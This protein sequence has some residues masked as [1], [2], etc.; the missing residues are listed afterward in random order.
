M[1]A[2]LAAENLEA[3]RHGAA[4]ATHSIDDYFWKKLGGAGKIKSKD[5]AGELLPTVPPMGEGALYRLS[6]STGKL[7]IEEV[8]RGDL[9][10]SMLSSD[11][12]SVVDPGP[13]LIVWIGSGASQRERAAAMNTATQYLKSQGKP[14]TTP[15]S[16]IKEGSGVRHATFQKIFAN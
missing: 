11:D 13:E 10:K 14:I 15:V 2:N 7:S 16:V 9:T 4:K 1:A 8:G 3:S 12:V 6:D 5:E